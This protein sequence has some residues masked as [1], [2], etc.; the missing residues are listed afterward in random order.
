MSYDQAYYARLTPVRCVCFSS[1]FL[2]AT[3][4]LYDQPI[5]PQFL[6]PDGTAAAVAAARISAT[7]CAA[8]E[9]VVA[10]VQALARAELPAARQRGA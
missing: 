5:A 4:R 1:S 6:H 9:A 8:K 7:C 2:Q 10:L 3:T